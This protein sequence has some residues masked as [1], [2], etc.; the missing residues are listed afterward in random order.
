[1][2]IQYLVCMVLTLLALSA[3]NVLSIHDR[4]QSILGASVLL[5]R[6][7]LALVYLLIPFIFMLFMDARSRWK[8]SRAQRD[9]L[10]GIIGGSGSKIQP[11]K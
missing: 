6:P 8:R 9:Q 7:Y 2:L 10:T 1:M 5:E 3:Q 4:I 11:P